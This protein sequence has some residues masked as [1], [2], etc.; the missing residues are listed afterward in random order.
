MSPKQIS[1]LFL[2][3][4]SLFAKEDTVHIAKKMTITAT[5][6][7]RYISETPANISVITQ[8]EVQNSPAK[9]V[10][11]LL[12]NEV[13]IQGKRVVGMGEGVP[14]DLMIRGI[15]GALLGS[16]T[17]ILIDG[18]PT[19]ASGTPFLILNEIPLEIIKSVEIIR[20]P[21]SSLYGANAFGGVINILTIRGEGK[22]SIK[23]DLE[24]T[25]PFSLIKDQKDDKS[26]STSFEES[27]WQTNLSGSG[28]HKNINYLVS[29]GFRTVGNY[30]QTDS[31]IIRK[32]DEV[33]AKSPDNHDYYDVR[34]F[35]KVGIDLT[36]AL[37]LQLNGRFFDSELGFGKTRQLTDS[38]DI[39]TAGRK[40]IVSP[41][42]SYYWGDRFIL[43]GSAYY[44]GMVGEFWNEEPEQETKE[45]L[46]SYWRSDMND[47]QA[48]VQGTYILEDLHV[49]TGGIDILDNNITF[50]DKKNSQTDQKI[51][52]TT[53]K[54]ANIFNM[55]IYLQ[56]DITFWERL[57]LI[58]GARA[59]IHSSFG[60]AISPKVGLLYRIIKPLRFR[61][62][63][64]KAFRA[65]TLSELYMPSTMINPEFTIEANSDL[66]PE[67]L[68]AF[69][70]SMEYT[71]LPT[72]RMQ[73][74]AFY[75][76]MS[77][78]I[79][80]KAVID[81]SGG[82]KP[83]VTHEN[84]AEAWSKGIELEAE[85]QALSWM[86]IF[87]NGVIQESYNQ[88]ASDM[89][90]DQFSIEDDIPLDYIPNI[91]A[92]TGIR[93]GKKVGKVALHSTLTQAYVGKRS[94]QDWSAVTT[95]DSKEVK[96][97]LGKEA[98]IFIN[99]PRIFLEEYFRTDA[100]LRAEFPQKWWIALNVQNI[101][102]TNFEEYGGTRAPGRFAS[103][104]IGGE[105]TLK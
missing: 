92:N 30:L 80:Q 38:V 83:Y 44:R 28:S 47:W 87:A 27:L 6:T 57:T 71:P 67:Y 79:G 91:T 34:L 2:L 76:S 97:V 65:P 26:I 62:S 99:P 69:D 17:L 35:T 53:A 15:P 24:T 74:G 3:I 25:L 31:A 77:D 33:K 32:E 46:P 75:N 68:W 12:V 104:K 18:I 37:S 39:I 58:S 50:G 89:A 55:G 90:Q 95:S 85:A 23:A 41:N 101:F 13:A 11:D 102:N 72:L 96:I 1:L 94:Y 103:I 48:E 22:P 9:N 21:Q 63:A 16:R 4:I 88:Y 100:S 29:G 8:E 36:D 73:V 49:L 70:A 56:D 98:N 86:H 84:I 14:S 93:F 43:R 66:N 45:Y 54:D 61:S 7:N 40:W 64:G 81:L 20:G 19:N 78:L 5:R 59:D 51:A 105:F 60:T 42:F 82:T 10:D 52:R